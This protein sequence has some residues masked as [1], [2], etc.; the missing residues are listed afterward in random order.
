MGLPAYR[1][2]RLSL[3]S[4]L[5]TFFFFLPPNSRYVA[6]CLQA[7]L[8]HIKSCQPELPVEIQNACPAPARINLCSRLKKKSLP[9]ILFYFIFATFLLY[10]CSAPC[11]V[12][13]ISICKGKVLGPSLYP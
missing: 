2:I 5:I 3:N 11:H 12:E 10:F 4:E 7:E 6:F 1:S 8:Q 9:V 13:V